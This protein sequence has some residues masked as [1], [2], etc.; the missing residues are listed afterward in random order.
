MQAIPSM[1][2]SLLICANG[3]SKSEPRAMATG[4]SDSYS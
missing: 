4:H 3:I 2:I 1:I